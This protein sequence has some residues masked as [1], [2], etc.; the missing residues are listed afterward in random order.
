MQWYKGFEE[1]LSEVFAE[2][3]H[4]ISRFP[5]PLN[6][7]GLAY[8]DKFHV[9]KE[10]SS[11]NYICYLLPFWLKDMANLPS[12]S[13]K[14]LALA[15][16]FVMLYFFIQDDLMD[17]IEQ[18]PKEVLPLGNLF[19]LEFLEI[20]RRYFPSESVFWIYLNEYVR[21]WSE[22]VTLEKEQDFFQSRI[23]R[24]AKKAS[25][26][27]LAS[28]GALL[29]ADQADQIPMVSSSIDLT[30]ITLQMV[31]DWMDWEQD[32]TEGAYNCLLSLIQAERK[33]LSDQELT[34]EE[35]KKSL[36]IHGSLSRYALMAE[37]NHTHLLDCTVQAPHLLSFHESLLTSLNQDAA[38]IHKD[39]NRLALGGFYDWLSKNQEI[40]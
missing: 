3:E 20:Y 34:A 16:V 9:F 30:L 11:K 18:Q 22:S 37:A 1:E 29:L 10:N 8:L 19:Y 38:K 28:T 12:E 32:L 7:L 13:Y 27:K 4:L 5:T 23:H 21:E 26:V 25:P 15:N 31:D 6:R 33:P 2:A 36:Y 40:F 17:S 35:V 39:R 14:N 24:V